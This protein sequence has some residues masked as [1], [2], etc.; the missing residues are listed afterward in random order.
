MTHVAEVRSPSKE[1]LIDPH[2]KL[3]F[4]PTREKVKQELTKH[5]L[6]AYCTKYTKTIR[7]STQCDQIGRLLKVLG[8]MISFKSSPNAW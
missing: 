1:D 6:K 2:S 5:R 7:W 3:Q 4:I 8:D